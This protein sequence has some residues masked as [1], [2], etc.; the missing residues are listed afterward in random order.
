MD[1][2][3]P[4][5]VHLD[6]SMPPMEQVRLATITLLHAA[7]KDSQGAMHKVLE[8]DLRQEEA[9]FSAMVRKMG[10]WSPEELHA[11]LCEVV[12]VLAKRALKND[13]TLEEF[14][15]RVDAMWGE[16]H[17]ERPHFQRMGDA[18]HP[19]DPYTLA[20]VRHTLDQLVA[21]AAQHPPKFP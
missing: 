1:E 6:G 12:G 17:D 8:Q 18:A 11:H 2:H 13:A 20:S 9:L 10:S 14:T 7:L 16:L 3:D 19:D 5:S 4:K 15:R 21:F